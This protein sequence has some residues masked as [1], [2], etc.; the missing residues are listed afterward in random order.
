MIWIDIVF[1]I[2]IG[3]VAGFVKGTSGFASSLVAIPLL[4]RLGVSASGVVTMMIT[5]NIILNLLLVN[6]HKESYNLKNI[7][8]I[9]PIIRKNKQ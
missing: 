3:L 6:E 4:F 2:L 8:T 5:V 7:K 1:L 9:L